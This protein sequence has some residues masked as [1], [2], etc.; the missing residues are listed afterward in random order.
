MA[1][2]PARTGPASASSDRSEIRKLP[3]AV[4]D[5]YAACHLPPPTILLARDAVHFARLIC[6]LQRR[7]WSLRLVAL[8]A[9]ALLVGAGRLR[10]ADLGLGVAGGLLAIGTIHMRRE[11]R[12][13]E[14]GTALGLAWCVGQVAALMIVA[15]AAALFTRQ[16]SPGLYGI[17]DA[18]GGAAAF[19]AALLLLIEVLRLSWIRSRSLRGAAGRGGRVVFRIAALGASSANTLINSRL[20]A[21]LADAERPGPRLVDTLANVRFQQT[22]GAIEREV[23]RFPRYPRPEPTL[24]GAAALWSTTAFRIGRLTSDGTDPQSL[25]RV[26]RAGLAVHEMTDAACLFHR[27]A[28]VLPAGALAHFTATTEKAS[29]WRRSRRHPWRSILDFLDELS[30]SL[31]VALDLAPTIRWADRLLARRVTKLTDPVQRYEAIRMMGT[32]RFMRALAPGPVHEDK[33]GRLYQVGPNESP[34]VFVLVR[35]RVL[36]PGGMPLQHW[37]SVPPHLATAREAVAWTFGMGET[38]YQPTA[39]S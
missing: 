32:D 11:L 19:A 30:P 13:E 27:L 37:I 29:S 17:L 12:Q 7:T 35:D 1:L 15:I 20:A 9:V 23:Q 34:N 5:L 14:G 3:D 4:R 38:E 24:G 21:A 2:A 22:R 18:A 28:I 33:Y 36:G 26:L 25:P 8:F 31:T 6:R 10:N 39:E 16:P